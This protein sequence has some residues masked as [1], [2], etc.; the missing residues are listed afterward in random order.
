MGRTV[1]K[2]FFRFRFKRRKLEEIPILAHD[3]ENTG[4]DIIEVTATKRQEGDDDE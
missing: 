2:F 3:I 4:H 1:Q